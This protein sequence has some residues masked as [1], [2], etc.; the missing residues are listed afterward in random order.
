MCVVCECVHAS[1]YER[2]FLCRTE[3]VCVCRGG[4]GGGNLCVNQKEEST[5]NHNTSE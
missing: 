5:P 3:C 1:L 4:G 2:V